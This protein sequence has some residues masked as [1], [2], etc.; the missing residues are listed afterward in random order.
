MG[1]CRLHFLLVCV[2]VSIGL[3]D[4]C[5]ANDLR[6]E[7]TKRDW[8]PLNTDLFADHSYKLISAPSLQHYPY[9]NYLD[10]RLIT[11]GNVPPGTF[12]IKLSA[13]LLTGCS[14]KISIKNQ[15]DDNLN[16]TQ[17]DQ[18]SAPNLPESKEISIIRHNNKT[19]S[20]SITIKPDVLNDTI[21]QFYCSLAYLE[22]ENNIE[23]EF[24]MSKETLL[25]YKKLKDVLKD[26]KLICQHSLEMSHVVRITFIV[27]SRTIPLRGYCRIV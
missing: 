19:A 1:K 9:Y 23:L 2:L 7:F 22:M 3:K 12:R 13:F 8:L 10:S 20:L 6:E 21:K 16:E 5:F 4:H 26:K 14:L 25:S 15:Y 27:E 18:V 24:S 11:I 17:Y